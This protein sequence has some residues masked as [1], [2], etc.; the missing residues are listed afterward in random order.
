MTLGNGAEVSMAVVHIDDEPLTCIDIAS[1]ARGARVQLGEAARDRIAASRAIVDRLVNGEDLIYGLNTGLGH[2]RN[3]RL[4]AQQ[5]EENQLFVVRSHAGGIGPPLAPDVVRAAMAVRL[6]G[7]ARGG[8]GASRQLADGYVDLLNAGVTPIV[9]EVGS[10]GAS[11]LGHMA[12]IALVLIGEGHA[13]IGET[14]VAGREALARAHLAPVRLAPK[15]GLTAVSANGVSIGHAALVIERARRLADAADAVVALSL[16]A[17][18]GNLSIVDPIAAAA[19]PVRGQALAAARIRALLE[20]SSLCVGSPSVQDPLSFRVTPQVHGAFREVLAAAH[21]AVDAE[22]AAM[23]DNPLVAVAEGR[24]I[25]NGNF[26]PM[27]MALAMDA[28]RPAIAHVA[29]IADRRAGHV[30]DTLISDPDVSTAA[31][32][33]RIGVA[34]LV[35]YSIAAR[36][37]ELRVL[38]G[39][40]SL[41]IGPLDLGVEDHATN[42]PAVV[43]RTDEALDVLE[44][45]LAGELLLAAG[46]LAWSTADQTLLASRTRWMFDTI[47]DVMSAA[48]I[49]AAAVHAAARSLLRGPLAASIDRFERAAPAEPRP[50]MALGD[51]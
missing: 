6:A 46:A 30:W 49:D 32:L 2:M 51:T 23:D 21:A 36:T 29:Q 9:P 3:D 4:D 45:V 42:A 43:R 15:D 10:V 16:E 5:L 17:A 24:M 41:D 14:V 1:I 39:P 27:L 7:I 25:S 19:K 22:L 28:L 26:H 33:A 40:A 50:A 47:R 34:P 38:A 35:R 12:A 44:D 11:D 18:R 37:A 20:G 8:S 13:Q 31:G 48:D